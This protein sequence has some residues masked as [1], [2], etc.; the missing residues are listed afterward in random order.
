[1]KQLTNTD[2][3]LN[4]NGSIYHLGLHAEQIYSTIITVGDPGRVDSVSRHFDFIDYANHNREFKAV[5]GRIG[6]IP[7]MV[8][9]TGIGTDNIDIVLNEIDAL[10]NIDF[11]T[12]IINNKIKSLNIIRLGTSGSLNKNIDI[13]S[14]VVSEYVIGFDGLAHF[15]KEKDICTEEL[16]DI[17]INH[18]NWKNIHA[19]PYAVRAS[20]NLLK[21]FNNFKKGITLTATG[22]YG[23]QSRELRLKSSIKNI[24]TTIQKLNYKNLEITNFEME[25]SALYFLGKSLGHNVLTICAILGNRLK[26]EYSQDSIKT[27]DN[28]I[29]AVLN[30][31]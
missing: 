21:K 13:D 16:E 24:H 4:N 19:R 2:L 10:V 26:Q 31:L 28:L 6:N 14:Y 17:F 11:K 18:T 1:M 23:P 22:F 25:T 30:K 15:Y 8:L 12:R 9:S 5:G 29:I 3:I 27:I 7:I 20:K